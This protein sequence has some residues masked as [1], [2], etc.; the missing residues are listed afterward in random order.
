MIYLV[1]TGRVR[2]RTQK[3][4]LKKERK[5]KKQRHYFLNQ[6]IFLKK[7]SQLIRYV[8][9]F[10]VSQS[11]AMAVTLPIGFLFNSF[12]IKFLK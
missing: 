12:F 1:T 2:V 7:S 4:K 11:F 10:L 8:T 9:Q 6:V 3:L 5:K